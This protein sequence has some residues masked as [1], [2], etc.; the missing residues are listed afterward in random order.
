M[1]EQVPDRYTP[2]GLGRFW[3]IFCDR[4]LKTNLT[5][6]NQHHDCGSGEL[7]CVRTDF[8]NSV[9]RC[10]CFQ[11]DIRESVAL[12]FDGTAIPNDGERNAGNMQLPH[13][14][15]DVIVD[16]IGLTGNRQAEC[17]EKRDENWLTRDSYWSNQQSYFLAPSSSS[18]RAFAS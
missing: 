13:L 7:L 18:A 6:I 12:R 8:V 10:G 1:R 16:L 11:L 5:L 4:V 3:K 9:L 14:R 15:H 2:P 17:D